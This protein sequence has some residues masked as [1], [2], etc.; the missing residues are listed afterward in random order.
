MWMG[1]FDA[2][3][4]WWPCQC[5]LYFSWPAETIKTGFSLVLI[6]FSEGPQQLSILS[7]CNFAIKFCYGNTFSLPTGKDG[8]RKARKKMGTARAKKCLLIFQRKT[9]KFFDMN[10]YFKSQ[11]SAYFRSFFFLQAYSFLNN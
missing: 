1:L 10:T 11:I 2:P 4:R 3:A 5:R 7:F 6:W 8:V 9:Y